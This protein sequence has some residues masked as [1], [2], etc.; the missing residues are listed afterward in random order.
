VE[1][2]GQWRF[3][4]FFCAIAKFVPPPFSSFFVPWVS[5]LVLYL[6]LELSPLL[7]VGMN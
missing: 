7:M 6:L 1:V 5:S 2:A 4:L 3:R